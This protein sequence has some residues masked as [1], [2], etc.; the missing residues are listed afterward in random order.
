MFKVGD[1]VVLKSGGPPMTV[2]LEK[3]DNI[4]T[5]VWFVGDEKKSADFHADTLALDDG[6]PPFP[7]VG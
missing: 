1:T 6:M 3:P 5:C 4:F 2:L 7:S